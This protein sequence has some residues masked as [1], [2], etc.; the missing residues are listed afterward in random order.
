LWQEMLIAEAVGRVSELHSRG[1]RMPIFLVQDPLEM[2]STSEP[3]DGA[4]LVRGCGCG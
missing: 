2:R 4:D 1:A 3:E